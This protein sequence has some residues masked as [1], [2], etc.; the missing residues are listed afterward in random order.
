MCQWFCKTFKIQPKNLKA[1]LNIYM[2]QND[3]EIKNF[4]SDLTKIPL[5]NFGKSFIKP[6]NKNYK[7]NNL[8]YGTI[9]IRVFNGTNFRHRVF[10]WINTVLKKE[11]INVET[12]QR[13]W[14]K[15]KDNYMRS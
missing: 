1:H 4:W 8:Y 12:I 13:K 10:S 15:L 2:N 7:S 11:K 5:K 3:L 6:T 9:K 14:Y